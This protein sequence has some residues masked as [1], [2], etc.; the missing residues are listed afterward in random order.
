MRRYSVYHHPQRGYRAVKDGFCWPA[1]FFGVWWA[2]FKGLWPTAFLLLVINAAFGF[3]TVGLAGVLS[4]LLGGVMVSVFVGL[5]GNDWV[6]SKLW[7]QGFKHVGVVEGAR[8]KGAAIH[9]RPRG[10]SLYIDE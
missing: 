2:L 9:A 10:D 8:T 3:V 6:K 4:T 1:F 7:R 5:M